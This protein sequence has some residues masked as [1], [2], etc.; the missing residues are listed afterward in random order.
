MLRLFWEGRIKLVHHFSGCPNALPGGVR[1]ALQ[2][3]MY[4]E[5]YLYLT[6]LSNMVKP[7]RDE[8]NAYCADVGPEVVRTVRATAAAVGP[9]AVRGA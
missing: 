1:E 5:Y 2:I 6:F 4:W 8:N 9:W 3:I 7:S